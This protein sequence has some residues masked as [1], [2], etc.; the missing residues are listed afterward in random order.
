MASIPRILPILREP[1]RPPEAHSPLEDTYLE[2]NLPVFKFCDALRRHSSTA[3]VDIASTALIMAEPLGMHNTAGGLAINQL[4]KMKAKGQITLAQFLELTK[5]AEGFD[6]E[7][8]IEVDMGNEAAEAA[9]AA[10]GRG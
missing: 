8:P 5:E 9:A 1:G 2:R 7:R 3:L 10:L 6:E 4:L